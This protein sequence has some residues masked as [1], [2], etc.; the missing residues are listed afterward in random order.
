M[1]GD[2]L[3]GAGLE[4]ARRACL[5][6]L[7]REARATLCAGAL[8]AIAKGAEAPHRAEGLDTE[9]EGAEHAEHAVV[10]VGAKV[11]S[12]AKGADEAD[13]RAEG[14]GLLAASRAVALKAAIDA[15]ALDLGDSTGSTGSAD[16]AQGKEGAG[17]AM[18]VATDAEGMATGAASGAASVTG[19]A[20]PTP[21]AGWS[22]ASLALLAR[23]EALLAGWR[24]R[25][26]TGAQIDLQAD[27]AWYRCKVAP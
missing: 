26:A 15:A 4:A 2:T 23:L 22:T 19:D 25:V 5:L 24:G 9:G 11:G 3:R 7:L 20:L 18:D 12:E 27:G 14:A 8:E 6:G 21:W 17:A 10:S 16:P 1:L 13:L